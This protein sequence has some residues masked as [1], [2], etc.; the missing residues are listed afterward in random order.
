[1][2][3]GTSIDLHGQITLFEADPR[4]VR[5]LTEIYSHDLA[6]KLCAHLG[7]GCPPIRW[8]HPRTVRAARAVNR[9]GADQA[10]LDVSEIMSDLERGRLTVPPREHLAA[11]TRQ[12]WCHEGLASLARDV[13]KVDDS[14]TLGPA[15]GP[16]APV[17]A[18]VEEAAGVLG[19]VWPEAAAE[20]DTL[21][22]VIVYVDGAGFRSATL[23]EMFGAVYAG[24]GFLDS[25]PACFEMLLHEAGHHS[26]YL[27]NAF[28]VFVTNTAEVATHPLRP[29]PR[30][31]GG[32]AHAAHVLARMATGLDRWCREPGAPEEARRRRE[33]ALDRLSQTLRVLGDRARWT[34]AGERYFA[35]LLARETALRSGT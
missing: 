20:L 14:Y 19:R 24:V 4:A 7:V 12:A 21:V 27:R 22:R 33:D 5:R 1:M 18:R 11:G 25:V 31:I 34:P 16:I 23:R 6:Q 10:S 13:G 35:E 26:L 9:A 28:T 15:E 2:S 8:L 30:P 17:R 32:I 29:D 3:T